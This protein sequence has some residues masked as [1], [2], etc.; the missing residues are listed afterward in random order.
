L[1]SPRD[2]GLIFRKKGK[3]GDAEGLRKAV[4]DVN[5]ACAVMQPGETLEGPLSRCTWQR[6]LGRLVRPSPR[7]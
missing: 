4:E 7:R 5:I 3:P 6:A 2:C 1:A